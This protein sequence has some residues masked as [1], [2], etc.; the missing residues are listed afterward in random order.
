MERTRPPLHLVAEKVLD[1]Y[2]P[3]ISNSRQQGGFVSRCEAVARQM[4]EGC[5]R[6]AAADVNEHLTVL[7]RMARG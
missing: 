2:T 5:P 4:L 3:D 1:P 6:D 7:H